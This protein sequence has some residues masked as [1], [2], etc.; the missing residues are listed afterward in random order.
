MKKEISILVILELWMQ[1]N[2]SAT[3]FDVTYACK[4]W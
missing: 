1:L 2:N 3:L 4:N